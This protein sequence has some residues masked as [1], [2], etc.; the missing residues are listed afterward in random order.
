MATMDA[1]VPLYETADHR[2]PPLD[3]GGSA[4]HLTTSTPTAARPSRRSPSNR[5]SRGCR[6]RRPSHART[7]WYDV[8]PTESRA[9]SVS[10]SELYGEYVRITGCRRPCR[11]L[12]SRQTSTRIIG[13]ADGGHVV[14]FVHLVLYTLALHQQRRRGNE[15]VGVLGWVENE[16]TR[17][18]DLRAD[19]GQLRRPRHAASRPALRAPGH[20]RPPRPQRGQP[21]GGTVVGGDRNAPDLV[22]VAP[23]NRDL[24]GWV[25]WREPR[26]GLGWGRCR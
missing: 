10:P 4:S 2:H 16:T 23:G 5:S 24:I 25:G 21:D 18:A 26:L 20:R 19:E 7:L 3:Q 9:G 12:V 6:A 13:V 14:H 15:I 11:T 17:W 22:G 1:V 8:A